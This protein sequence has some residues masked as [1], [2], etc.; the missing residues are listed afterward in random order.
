MADSRVK[1]LLDSA[2]VVA[3]DDGW[4]KMPDSRMLTLHLAHAGVSLTVPRIRAIRQRVLLIE[5]TAAQGE[6]YH[7]LAE[8]VFAVVVDGSKESGRKAGFV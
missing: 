3:G 6:V 5:A 7:V 8:D 2:G 1:A 4:L